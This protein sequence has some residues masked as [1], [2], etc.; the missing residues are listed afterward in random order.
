MFI[1][2]NVEI[3]EKRIN[4][5]LVLCAYKNF[6]SKKETFKFASHAMENI[7]AYPYSVNIYKNIRFLPP[8]KVF[9]MSDGFPSFHEVDTYLNNY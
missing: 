2:Y 8:T 7:E 3:I 4:G 9:S 5:K 1:S 6:H